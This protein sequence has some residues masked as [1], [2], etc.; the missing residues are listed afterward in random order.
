ML[1]LV[2]KGKL[3]GCVWIHLGYLLALFYKTMEPMYSRL[4]CLMMG[5]MWSNQTCG[6]ETHRRGVRELIF[7]LILRGFFSTIISPLSFDGSGTP[8]QS[9]PPRPGSCGSTPGPT[10]PCPRPFAG[11]KGGKTVSILAGMSPVASFL[12]AHSISI[13]FTA[14]QAACHSHFY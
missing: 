12:T 3:N 1:I 6:E 8:G 14:T 10:A 4:S 7:E 13:H 5:L 2:L 9:S 11:G